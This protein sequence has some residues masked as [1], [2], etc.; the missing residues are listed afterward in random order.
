MHVLKLITESNLESFLDLLQITLVYHCHLQLPAFLNFYLSVLCSSKL[1]ITQA[2]YHL[3]P[4]SVLLQRTNHCLQ[5]NLFC[6][7]KAFTFPPS[8]FFFL[9]MIY[10][11]CL[12]LL[13]LKNYH[14]AFSVWVRG[15]QGATAFSHPKSKFI[16][17]QPFPPCHLGSTPTKSNC[18]PD[19]HWCGSQ[20]Y[21][22][23]G[24]GRWAL[25]V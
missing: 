19:V 16:Q 17:H 14:R 18:V 10:K 23:L 15:G 1:P 8:S 3:G 9:S 2:L 5:V 25:G 20:Y 12:S 11:I 24:P 22:C 7:F 21:V 13:P 4:F 6:H